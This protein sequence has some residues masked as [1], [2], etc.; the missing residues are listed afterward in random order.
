MHA[1]SYGG[2][3][4]GAY[5]G[6]GIPGAYVGSMPPPGMPPPGQQDPPP[7]DTASRYARFVAQ[8]EAMGRGALSP[9]LDPSTLASLPALL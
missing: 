8:E 6:G 4:P 3:I 9:E 2:G 7:E 1:G 5:S